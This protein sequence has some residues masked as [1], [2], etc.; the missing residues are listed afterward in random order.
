M[1]DNPS[2]S[3]SLSEVRETWP[4]EATQQFAIA[5]PGARPAKPPPD[6]GLTVCSALARIDLL[7]SSQIINNTNHAYQTWPR[8][9]F[10][11][12]NIP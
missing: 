7:A 6:P 8:R 10:V 4:G 1:H 5:T 3:H 2:Q 12:G 9:P 11:G